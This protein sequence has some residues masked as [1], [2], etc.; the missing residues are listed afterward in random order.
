MYNLDK[1]FNDFYKNHV[2]LPSDK[3]NELRD[4]KNLNLK[5]L[6]EG[7]EE[8]NEESGTNYKI[9]E[10]RLQGSMAMH[11]IVQN[12]SNEYDIDVA[13]IFDKDNIADK[14]PVAIKNVIVDALKRK[15]KGFAKPPEVKTNCVR[16]TYSDGYHIDFAVYRRYKDSD[17]IQEYTYEHAGNQWTLRNPAAINNWFDEEINAKGQILR[18]IIRLSKMFCKSRTNW[19]NMPGGLLQT[20]LCDEM[21]QSYDRLDETFYYTMKAIKER[22]ETTIEV[23][24]PTDKA[25]SLLQTEAHRQKMRDWCRRLGDNLA[26]LKVLFEKEC[27]EA[28]AKKAWWEFFEHDYWNV[29]D[30]NNSAERTNIS[31]P[32][33]VNTEQFIEDLYNVDEQYVVK[34]GCRISKAGFRTMPILQFFERFRL[35]RLPQGY[36][37]ECTVDYTDAPRY[38]KI[39]WKVRNVGFVAE[40]RN[41]IRGQIKERGKSIREHSD[42]YGAHFIE[43]YLIQGNRCIAIG[44]VNV[45][46]DSI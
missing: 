2:V 28:D 5:R 38:D 29:T 16:I 43:C 23:F 9:A 44:R 31:C 36:T 41:M 27:S 26:K 12:D 25:V 4:K 1:F 6:R 13:V 17:N 18:K 15:C 7:L 46:I 35:F 42:F 8:Y 22:L 20:V 3:Q 34:I 40:Q 19:T 32:S 39:L 10:T 14:G 21:L 33:F 30:K 37:I 45:P 11:T 24:N